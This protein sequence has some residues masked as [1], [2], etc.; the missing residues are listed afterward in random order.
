MVRLGDVCEVSSG[1]SAPQEDKYFING[2]YHFFR[3]SDVAREH[4]TS[5]LTKCKDYLNEEG[6][7]KFKLFKKDTILFPKSAASTFLNHRAVLVVDGYVSS[8]L[9]TIYP[10]TEDVLSNFI[11]LM[12]LKV[13]AKNLTS[14]QNYPSLKLKEIE[15]IHI[16][17]PPLEVQEEI[18]SII[19]GY[20]KLIDGC[21]QVV[22]N[23]KPDVETELDEE[24]K[25]YLEAHPDEKE[26]LKD[27]WQWRS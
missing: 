10:K 5:N 6:I 11:F 4:I 9:A 27:G 21:K 13:D 20:Q 7:K 2:K 22:E 1:D 19:E 14:D 3:T 25:I 8:H 12:L 26:K 15:N 17:L 23:W 24:L 16:P 18:V